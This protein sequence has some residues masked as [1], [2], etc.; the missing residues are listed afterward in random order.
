MRR[1]FPRSVPPGAKEGTA[2][3]RTG[4]WPLD[5][6]DFA[7]YHR[8]APS[9]LALRECL[10][11]RA[12]R[13]YE[14]EE[15]I[16]DI[17]CG[18]GVFAQLAYPGKQIWGI[19]VNPQEIGRAQATAAYSTLVCGSITEASLPPRFFRGAIANCSLEHVPDLDAALRNVG[20]ALQP[21]SR[22]IIIVPSPGWTRLLALPELLE[23]AGLSA[24]AQAYG[25]ALDRVFRHLHIE[26]EA[27]WSQRLARAGF[28][29]REVAEIGGRR[30]SWMFDL[31]LYP[32][33]LGLGVKKLTGR[34]V[35]A[36][37][38]R[39]LVVDLTRRA[40]DGVAAQI[41]DSDA[42]S[43]LLIVAERAA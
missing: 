41:A 40:L 18:D 1:F 33:L 42:G 28:E 7:A 30:S 13:A 20:G 19:D 35:L 14:L 16:L 26:D 12:V 29:L 4:E 34:W 21:G 31:M 23:R 38:L 43:E 37:A 24:L 3:E 22:F 2:T 36:P 17:G 27:A 6:R 11:L 25:D 8:Y 32:S 5:P 39:P 9:A 10:R 15:P